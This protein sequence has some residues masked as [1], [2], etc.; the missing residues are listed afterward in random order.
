MS[1]HGPA[2]AC[3]I[4]SQENHVLNRTV[5]FP[6]CGRL[7]SSLLRCFEGGKPPLLIKYKIPDLYS[8]RAEEFEKM[9]RPRDE[10]FMS[11]PWG[12]PSENE[13]R[14]SKLT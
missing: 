9:T 14:E 10:C 11:P 8:Q 4:L 5:M 3:S 1:P 12:R 7:N 6:S 2:R 13:R